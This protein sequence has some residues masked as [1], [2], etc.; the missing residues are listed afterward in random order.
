VDHTLPPGA[1]SLNIKFS[2]ACCVYNLHDETKVPELCFQIVKLA[3]SSMWNTNVQAVLWCAAPSAAC[4]TLLP[5]YRPLPFPVAAREARSHCHASAMPSGVRARVSFFVRLIM[6]LFRPRMRRRV[7]VTL[8]L[9][10]L[11]SSSNMDPKRAREGGAKS[12]WKNSPTSAFVS[13]V[14]GPCLT[15]TVIQSTQV[16]ILKCSCV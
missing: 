9:D 3:A 13:R 2:D 14:K 16:M 12:H 11:R 7:T 8:A 6:S 1:R 5:A 10:L 4:H 15:R